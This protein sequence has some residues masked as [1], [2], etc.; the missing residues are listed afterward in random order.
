MAIMIPSRPREYDERSKENYIFEALKKLP[1][2]YYVIHSFCITTIIDNVIS[3]GESD[4]IVFNPQKGILVIESKAGNVSYYDD[5]W[6]YDGGRPMSHQGPYKQASLGK[7]NLF[8]LIEQKNSTLVTKCKFLHTV[9]FPSLPREQ[10][11]KIDFPEYALPL[12]DYTLTKDDLINPTEMIEKIFSLDVTKKIQTRLTDSDTKQILNVFCKSFHVVPSA[13]IDN[14]LTE[15]KFYHLLQEQLQVLHFLNGQKT[16][17]VNGAAGT[18]KTIIACE[19]A[20]QLADDGKKV[21]FLC[22][23]R[24]LCD[25]LREDYKAYPLIEF[26][27]IDSYVNKLTGKIN[28]YYGAAQ[29]LNHN[30]DKLKYDHVVIDEAQDFG[31]QEIE[32]SGLIDTIFNI[33]SIEREIGSFYSF[34]DR[35]QMINNSRMPAFINEADC[36]VTLYKNCRNTTNIAKTS[37]LPVVDDKERRRL[38]YLD[39]INIGKTP[40]FFFCKDNELT[41]CLDAIIHNLITKRNMKEKDIVILTLETAEKSII[42]NQNGL[43]RRKIKFTTTRKFKGLESRSVIL[44][45]FDHNIFEAA[46]L[47]RYYVGTSRAKESLDIITSMSNDECANILD[48]YFKKKNVKLKHAQSEFVKEFQGNK[49]SFFDL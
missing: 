24:F 40:R 1:N 38:Q 22:F 47:L 41:Q 39:P 28:D 23:N 29:I 21:L 6:R 16:V 46:K 5:E 17:A 9:W 35:L 43:Y 12:Q 42:P 19:R 48:N 44:V 33:I 4:F 32:E 37:L 13:N 34:Y 7:H 36:K 26:F 20:K 45:D 25:K 3:E 8:N 11:R 18:G 49:K 10:V 14:D 31:I 27:T 15:I 30:T 2:D